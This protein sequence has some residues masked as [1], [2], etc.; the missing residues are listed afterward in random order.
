[1]YVIHDWQL[2]FKHVGGRNIQ[3][4][5]TDYVKKRGD[6]L[7]GD[8]F[9][10]PAGKLPA[11]FVIHAVGPIYQS[12]SLGE[13]AELYEVV[14]QSLQKADQKNCRSI[15]MPAISTLPKAT[16]TTIEAVKGFIDGNTKIKIREIALVSH[17]DQA[18]VLRGFSKAAQH[19]FPCNT[20]KMAGQPY[21]ATGGRCFTVVDIKLGVAKH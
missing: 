8:T 1:M 9:V 12:G 13:E 10:T 21:Q 14:Y 6:V 5:C 19:V 3:A 4:K 20:F 17:P 18:D 16:K 7:P 15:A 2:I 11:K